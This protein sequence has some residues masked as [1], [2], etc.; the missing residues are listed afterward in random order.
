MYDNL[1]INLHIFNLNNYDYGV[2]RDLKKSKRGEKRN[3]KFAYFCNKKNI[4]LKLR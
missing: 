4:E 1:A 2:S 3:L